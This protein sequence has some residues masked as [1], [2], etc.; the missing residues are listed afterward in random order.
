M[1]HSWFRLGSALQQ[2]QQQQQA[3]V[4]ELVQQQLRSRNRISPNRVTHG[5]SQSIVEFVGGHSAAIN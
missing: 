4:C 3:S 5:E 2:Q 1:G